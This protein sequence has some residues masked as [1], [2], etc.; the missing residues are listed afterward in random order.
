MCGAGAAGHGR[1]RT[2]LV[3]AK[4][5]GA[6]DGI[7]QSLGILVGT[8]DGIDCVA[9]HEG[10]CWGTLAGLGRQALHLDRDKGRLLR[11]FILPYN[12]VAAGPSR[13]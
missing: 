1:V 3:R 8:R 9:G 2:A 5:L 11:R 13:E 4:A 10:L 12:R 6:E 7:G